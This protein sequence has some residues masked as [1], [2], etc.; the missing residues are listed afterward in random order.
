[1][2]YER[3]L[4]KLAQQFESFARDVYPDA[5]PLYTQFCLSIVH[6]PELLALA[7]HAPRGQPVPNLLFAA[8]QFLLLRGARQP[9]QSNSL[10]SLAAFYP[11]ITPDAAP[12][13]D[14]YPRLRAFCLEYQ[15]EIKH[16]LTT[17]RVQTNEV[18]RCA[19]LL[20]AFELIARR[21]AG[22]SLFLVEIGSSAGL[23]L[24]WDKYGY[25][26]GVL[27]RYGDPDSN[28]QLGCILRGEV[29]PPLPETM[30][31]V[32]ER[33]GI[34]LDPIDVHDPDETLWLRALVWPEETERAKLLR[35]AI[36]VAQAHSPRLLRGDALELL[37]QVI[38]AVPNDVTL[39]LFQSYALNQ[40]SREARERL[41][42]LLAEV[43]R[44]RD[45]YFVS[46]EWR[47]DAPSTQLGITSFEEGA[48]S[49][50]QLAW[51]DQHGAWLEWL[52]TSTDF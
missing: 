29:S 18:R 22:R 24:L 47:R 21:T 15:A 52:D 49:E 50:R 2:A 19:C 30:P 44:T 40:F 27:G 35:R 16:L 23:N 41:A 43:G 51:C 32:A 45:L 12:A 8:V 14:P 28:V 48:A 13:G 4:E 33:L 39:C 6:D 26:Y 10:R 9:A 42:G 34:D 46:M 11:T 5:S 31:R 20:P 3:P 36:G 7:N 17:R 25:D 37:P 1:M 38:Q